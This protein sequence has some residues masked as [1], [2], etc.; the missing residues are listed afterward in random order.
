MTPPGTR[1][2]QGAGWYDRALAEARP[3]I[4]IVA[5]V[6]DDELHDAAI[7]PIPREAHDVAVSIVVRPSG[8][9]PIHA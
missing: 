6:F 3:G 4:P 7:Q 8:V 1:L 9:T 2:G 5:L